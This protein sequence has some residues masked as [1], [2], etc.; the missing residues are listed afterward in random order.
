MNSDWPPIISPMLARLGSENDLS[1]PHYIWEPKLDGTRA[2][3]YKKGERIKILNRRKKWIEHRYPELSGIHRNILADPCIL[4]CEIVVLDKNNKP[5]FQL[6]QLRE[7]QEHPLKIELLS[8][9]YPAVIFAFD[10]LLAN[11][12]DMTNKPL[13][14]RKQR[15]SE[16]VKE[17][18]RLRLCMYT[19]DGRR[20]WESVKAMGLEGVMGKKLES[21]YQQGK[22]SEDWIKVKTFK[23]MDCVIL[24]YTPGEGERKDYFG[25][26]AIGAYDREKLIFL[27]KVGTGFDEETIRYLT[28]ELKKIEVPEK[29]VEEEPPYE[30]RWVRPEFVCEVR[31]LEVTDD[32]KLRAPVFLRL[33]RDKSPEEC[34]FETQK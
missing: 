29:P 23:T 25:A 5:D 11:E 16:I 12:E 21:T 3:V 10:V 6:L 2:I 4:D 26:L 22:R 15:L 14:E 13:R 7:Q 31:F 27:G 9:M 1:K 19:E 33:R 20:L 32:L 24:G 18:E 28:S 8:K 17:S 34:I 30:V